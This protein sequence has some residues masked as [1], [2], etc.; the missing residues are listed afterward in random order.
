[1][2]VCVCVCN[3]HTFQYGVMDIFRSATSGYDE[4]PARSYNS[5]VASSSRFYQEIQVTL[6]SGKCATPSIV[7][8]FVRHPSF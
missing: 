5:I 7:H 1:M 6:D 8:I 2:C 3:L 4:F